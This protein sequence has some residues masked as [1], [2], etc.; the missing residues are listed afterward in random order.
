[1]SGRDWADVEIPPQADLVP[2]VERAL[3]DLGGEAT[4]DQITL[5]ALELGRFSVAQLTQLAHSRPKRTQYG[6]ELRYRLS[7]AITAAHRQGTIEQVSRARW[8]L[9]G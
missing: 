4:R 7:W 8:R 1:M 3:S 5:R 9:A 2:L 6:T